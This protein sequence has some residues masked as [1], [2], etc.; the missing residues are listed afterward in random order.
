M[1]INLNLVMKNRNF[2]QNLKIYK[3]WIQKEEIQI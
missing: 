2:N 1:K 3:N